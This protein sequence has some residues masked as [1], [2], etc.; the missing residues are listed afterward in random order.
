MSHQRAGGTVSL[1][2]TASVGHPFPIPVF[3]PPGMGHSSQARPALRG[4][5]WVGLGSPP[6]PAG[7]AW[8]TRELP[9]QPRA[10][11]WGGGLPT[12]DADPAWGWG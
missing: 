2:T 1:T 11:S 9:A 12:A 5:S 4:A 10:G 7:P 6:M 3:T 8:G